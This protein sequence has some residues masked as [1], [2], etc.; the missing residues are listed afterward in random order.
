MATEKQVIE[1]FLEGLWEVRVHPMMGEYVVYCREKVVGSVCDNL[2]YVKIT[3]SSERLLT[4]LGT[5]RVPPYAGAKP[6][7]QVTG[8]EKGFIQELLVAVADDI[9]PKKKR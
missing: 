4:P 6:C 3:P 9:P 5:P 7:F 1:E 8:A 2:L